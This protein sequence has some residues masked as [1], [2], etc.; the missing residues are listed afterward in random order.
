MT[1]SM[2]KSVP[3]QGSQTKAVST[4]QKAVEDAHVAKTKN[5]RTIFTK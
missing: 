3:L 5:T 2:I 1:S 4:L